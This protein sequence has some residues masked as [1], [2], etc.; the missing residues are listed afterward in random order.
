MYSSDSTACICRNDIQI[1]NEN[2]NVKQ[3]PKR[4][5]TNFSTC[6]HLEKKNNNKRINAHE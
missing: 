3:K 5:V 1:L 4:K 2:T 6:K